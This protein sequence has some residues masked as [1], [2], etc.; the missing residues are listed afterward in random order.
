MHQFYISCP[1]IFSCLCLYISTYTS[2]ERVFIQKIVLAEQNRNMSKNVQREKCRYNDLISLD[3]VHQ[4]SAAILFSVL[5]W[6]TRF[7]RSWCSFV[8]LHLEITIFPIVSPVKKTCM[9]LQPGKQ[10]FVSW[11]VD[12]MSGI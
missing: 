1:Y 11:T 8:L 9:E 2:H 6:Y 7:L 12:G 5:Y 4:Q 10:K 3:C